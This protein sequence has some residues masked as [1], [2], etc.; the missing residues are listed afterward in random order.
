MV[1]QVDVPAGSQLAQPPVPALA[2]G[3][4]AGGRSPGQRGSLGSTLHGPRVREQ[5]SS[6]NGGSAVGR[7]PFSPGPPSRQRPGPCTS[8][9]ALEGFPAAGQMLTRGGAVWV[10]HPGTAVHRAGPGADPTDR[11][12]ARLGV[13]A[14]YRYLSAGFGSGA[15]CGSARQHSGSSGH[16]A[17]GSSTLGSEGPAPSPA[18][19]PIPLAGLARAVTPQTGAALGVGGVSPRSRSAVG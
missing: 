9:W 18:P 5:L 13:G 8:P 15:R 11:P 2:G 6:L 14:G 17:A 7:C 10:T 16:R 3:C 19:G 12:L 1:L 4:G